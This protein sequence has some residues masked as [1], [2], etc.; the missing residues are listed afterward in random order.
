MARMIP[1]RYDKAVA[2]SERKVFDRLRLDP[3]ADDWTVLHSLGL[4]RR[5]AK[6]YGEI[7]F[8]ILIPG[9]GVVCLEVKGGRI[10]CEDG[11]W[12]TRNRYGE[13]TALTR[14]PFEQAK[15]GMFALRDEVA[16]EFGSA[17]EV[18]RMVYAYGVVFTDVQSPPDTP[19][20]EDWEAIDVEG[21]REPIS[22]SL[23]RIIK[24]QAA[25]L[26]NGHRCSLAAL[27]TLG[28]LRDFL[29]PDF[30]VGIARSTSI[31]RSEKRILRLT[32][33]QYDVLDTL[34]M[35][36]HCL[37]EGAAGT[38]K[39]MLAL[40]FARR[41]R[42]E[43]REIVLLCYNRLLGDWIQR[44]LDVEIPGSTIVAGSF[45]RCLR[46][47]ITNSFCREEFLEEEKPA[48]EEDSTE[49][50][51]ETYPLF[52]SL[53]LGDSDQSCELLIIDEGQD[54]IRDN[55]LAVLDSWL[56]GGLAGGRWV[57]FGDFTRQAIYTGASGL[58]EGLTGARE[59]L[60]TYADHITVTSL[61]R[62][63]RNTRNIGEET[64]LLSGFNSLP[65]RLD[66]DEALP[67]DYRY[68]AS[69]KSQIRKAK[70]AINRL[71]EDGVS[72]SDIV[73]LSPVRFDRSIASEIEMDDTV[74]VRP[75]GSGDM[76]VPQGVVPFSTI[77]AFKGLESPVVILCDFD[78]LEGDRARSL[79]YVGMSRARSHLV[80]VLP[81]SIREQ[82]AEAFRDR[83]IGWDAG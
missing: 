7:D 9:S 78:S 34:S 19:E 62:N 28:D 15:E 5:G 3:A 57:I 4:S 1:P 30:D 49:F 51:Q 11:I 68:C 22:R 10:R 55:Y 50:F 77:H 44:S 45:H 41:M 31:T 39:T 54:L 12:Y 76:L 79:L 70:D 60:G 83:L 64:A 18:S 21:L 35:N 75:I 74:T 13:E 32:A 8:V 82:V 33:E 40:E 59:L 53:A 69:R 29:R 36:M 38:G 26:G 72:P 16:R 2:V 27:A 52:G 67:V 80:M 24:K 61:S 42:G 73:V 37:V 58:Q 48:L 43:H 65:Y 63:C 66:D 71:L 17:A 56:V 46:S 14:S 81:E 47:V 6:P 25:K 23:R 20:F